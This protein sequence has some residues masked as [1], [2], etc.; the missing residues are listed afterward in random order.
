MKT[1]YSIKHWAE[2]DRPREKLILKGRQNLSDSE[3]LAIILG[4]GTRKKS[5]L[6]LAQEIMAKAGNDL[7][8]LGQYSVNDLLSFHG[9]GTA[10][11]VSIIAALELGRRRKESL[12]KERLRVTSS[13][14]AFEIL[15]PLLSDIRHEEFYILL[16]DKSNHVLKVEQISKG[17]VDATI[18]DGKI[19]FHL[20]LSNLASGIILAHNHPSGN[21]KASMEDQ[22]LTK[23]LAEFGQMV[24]I[25]ILDHLIITDY[26]YF[27]F[28]N[29]N[30]L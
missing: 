30:L 10:K 29:Q 16:L 17:G 13:E 9:V 19:I 14:V 2:D 25:H 23:K 21:L 24:G 11:A 26:G 12:Q 18:A 5:A 8:K 28:S 27:S 6:E 3:I 1:N 15:R 4:S 22:K 7:Y 20:A